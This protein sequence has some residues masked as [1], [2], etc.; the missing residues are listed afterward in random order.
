LEPEE[1][2]NAANTIIPPRGATQEKSS[3]MDKSVKIN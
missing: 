1:D 3:N 2:K